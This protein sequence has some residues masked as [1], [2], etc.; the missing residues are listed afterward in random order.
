MNWKTITYNRQ[1]LYEEV[2]NDPVTIVAKRYGLSDVGLHK[3]CRKLKVPVPGRGYW[4]QVKAGVKLK[5]TPL[6][7]HTGPEEIKIQRFEEPDMKSDKKQQNELDFLNESE[8]Q[9]LNDVCASII[10]PDT[11]IRP[12]P[13]VAETGKLLRG[14]NKPP[15]SISSLHSPREALDIA[16]T[17]TLLNRAL[18]SMDT[19]IKSLDKLGYIVKID[20]EQGETYAK[21]GNEKVRFR[22][23]EHLKQKD[24][25]LT[26]DELKRKKEGRL[27]ST[28][29]FD[30]YPSGELTLSI[31][32]YWANRKNFRDGAKKKVEDSLGEFI[33]TLVQTAHIL[34][35]R[36]E[37]EKRE[38]ELRLQKEMKRYELEQLRREEME[39]FKALEEEA[40]DWHRARIIREYVAELERQVNSK[41]IEPD[42]RVRLLEYIQWARDKADWLDP[43]VGKKDK[44]LGERYEDEDEE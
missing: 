31:D 26:P 22:L 39:E 14:M 6:P 13:L 28:H 5:K 27:Y 4:A 44:V 2:W 32:E 40:N 21:V 16:V 10:V 18:R 41:E 20:E 29:R 19:L 33:A 25:E 15:F 24:H 1:T 7:K 37:E 42:R 11:L 9:A 23:V 30:Y 43:L 3:V 36:H 8:R 38:K 17:E 35:L 12:H 34:K